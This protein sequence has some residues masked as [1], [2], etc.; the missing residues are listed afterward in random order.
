MANVTYRGDSPKVTWHG[1]DFDHGKSVKVDDGLAEK[2]AGNPFFDV[3]K[4]KASDPNDEKLEAKH[5]GGG[6]FSI[7]RGDAE[8]KDGLSKADADAFNGLS[9]EEKAEYVL[10]E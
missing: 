7:M 10:A 6:R 5:R 9:V 1:L 4:E 3:G 2:M 8:I